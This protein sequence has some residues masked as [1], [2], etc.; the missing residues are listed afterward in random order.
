MLKSAHRQTML[1]L[2]VA[3]QRELASAYSLGRA[4]LG[5]AHPNVGRIAEKLRELG[6]C[7]AAL[8]NQ[9]DRLNG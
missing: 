1:D 7:R 3:R 8:E 5:R 2:V 4:V 6:E 9:P